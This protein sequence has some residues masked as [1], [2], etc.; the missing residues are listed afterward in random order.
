MILPDAP[1]SASSPA[2]DRPAT[3]TDDRLAGG[4]LHLRGDRALPD[5]LVQAQFV[6]GQAGLPGSAERVAGRADGLVRFL[7]VLHLAG[8]DAGGVRHVLGAVQL[9]G[10][11]PGGLDR[12]LRQDRG[13]GP[14]IGDVTVLIQPLR[15]RHCV[16]GR[17]PQLPRGLLLQRG[18]PERRIRGPPVRLA[19]DRL[20]REISRLQPVSQLGGGQAVHH[21]GRGRLGLVSRARWRSV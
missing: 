18:R 3:R 15:H 9:A 7:R 1:N 17:V 21:A 4:V 2:E 10:L 13:V 14:H 20:D 19:L 16:L 11:A 8:V 12:G 5:Q 6:A